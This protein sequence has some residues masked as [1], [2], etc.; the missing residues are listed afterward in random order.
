[1]VR[2]SAL[3]RFVARLS[4][5]GTDT[6]AEETE[7]IHF[8]SRADH[9]LG[10]THN[11]P[12]NGSDLIVPRFNF[13]VILIIGYRVAMGAIV[14]VVRFGIGSP[15]ILPLCVLQNTPCY[16]AVNPCSSQHT[17]LLRHLRKLNLLL[18]LL[19]TK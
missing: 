6:Q 5:V 9:V 18:L 3:F 19:T 10:L 15:N 2:N 17:R 4:F 7:G 14:V 12:H 8:L 13:A 16:G 1:Q 11:A